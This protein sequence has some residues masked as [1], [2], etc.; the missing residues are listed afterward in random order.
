MMK[1]LALSVA[2]IGLLAMG[3]S[4]DYESVNTERFESQRIDDGDFDEFDFDRDERQDLDGQ[5][6]R[7]GDGAVFTNSRGYNVNGAAQ[8][9]QSYG[10]SNYFDA[11]LTRTEADSAMALVYITNL[12]SP[13]FTEIGRT[14]VFRNGQMLGDAGDADG[15]AT[16]LSVT[17]CMGPNEGN[18]EVDE[19]ASEVT[20][21]VEE[22]DEGEPML[23]MESELIDVE[24]ELEA[25]Q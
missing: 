20:V 1:K 15:N 22:T 17:G 18:W 11:T 2:G 16:T 25:A 6:V 19:P 24:M 5:Q 13:A 8:S 10:D 23:V 4:A 9:V 12:D 3:C 14:T 7:I 21:T